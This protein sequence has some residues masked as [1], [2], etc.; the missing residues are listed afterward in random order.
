ME[1]RRVTHEGHAL[2]VGE[3]PGPGP[4][5]VLMHGFPDNHH[6]YD[7][8]LP[9]LAGRHVV[10]FD[11]LGWGDSDKPPDFA[12]TADAQTHELD[13]VLSTPGL[14]RVILVAHDASGPPAIDWAL[15]HPERVERLVLLNTYYCTMKS[16]RS[17]E[18]I[19]LFS[20]PVVGPV[21]RWLSRRFGDLLF[22]RMY[23]WQVGRFFRDA[24][25]RDQYVPILYEQFARQPSAQRAFFGL[26]E[27]L[28]PMLRAHRRRLGELQR[29]PRPVRIVFGGADPYLNRDVARDLARLFPAADLQLLPTARHFVQMD[30][31]ARVAE[32]ITR[33]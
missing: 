15:A 1:T 26:N 16:L 13:S 10:T 4:G 18:A 17:P 14:E 20:T 6:L 23:R 32:E 3:Q 19:W 30:E 31:P 7:R 9:H 22:R 29:F 12:Y 24:N 28:R 8:V 33:N 21:A 25:V 5:I 27:D 2:W 11:F